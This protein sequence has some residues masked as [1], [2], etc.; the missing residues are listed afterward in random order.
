MPS[1][2]PRLT[3]AWLDSLSSGIVEFER[4]WTAG[5]APRL[6]LGPGAPAACGLCP[7]PE[8][9]VG[10]SCGFLQRA[11][12]E[13][14]FVLPLASEKDID[15]ARDEVYLAG[16]F[17]GWQAAIGRAE[18]RLAPAELDG[19]Q[20]LVWKGQCAGFHASPPPKFKFVTNEYYWFTPP[21]D[22]PNTAR[23]DR[24]NLNRIID[25]SRTGRH[26]W[27]FALEKPIELTGSWSVAV[28]G[29]PGGPVPM[30][31]GPFFHDLST[32]LPLGA[33]VGEGQT[34]FR[35]FA[36]RARTATLH[37]RAEPDG[38]SEPFTYP[39]SRRADADG[40]AGVWEVTLDQDLQG[41]FYWYT[42][43]GVREGPGSFDPAIRILDPYALAAVG[44]E[45]PGIVLSRE[46]IGEG[47]DSLETPAWQDLVI[48]E[49]HVR[50]LTALAPV[51]VT[52][53]ERRG[54]TGLIRWIE[55]PDF[56]LHKLGINCVELQ[57]VHQF[58]SRTPEEYHWGYMPNNYFA[59]A[60]A[61]ALEPAGAS[62]VREFQDVVA[63][64]HS[65]EIAVVLDVVYNHVGL[66]EHLIR[67]DGLYYPQR[68]RD[69]KLSNW[70][71]CGNDLRAGAA[72]VKRLIIDSCLHMIEAYG[73]DGFRFDLAEILGV[74]LLR[75][76]EAALKAV[77]PDVILIA[78]PWSFR[79]HIAGALRDT[80]WASWNDGYRD[81]LPK[82]VRGAGTAA[83]LEYFIRGSPWFFAK[84]PAQTVN[85]VE[86]HDDRT[87]IDTI[88][89][90][91][92]GD[93]SAPTAND[94]RRTH[95]MAAIL[96][97]SAGIPM[98]SAGQDFLR[99][100]RG[101][102]N[103]YQRGDLNALDYRRLYRFL[104][105]HAY[106]A[107]WIDFRLSSR[108]GRLLRQFPR[109][110]DGFYSFFGARDQAPTAMLCNADRSDGPGRLLF[111]VNPTQGDVTVP[112]GSEV[113]DSGPWRLVADQDRFYP[114]GGPGAR[115]PVETNLFLPALG[116]GL[117]ADD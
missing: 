81:F 57:P 36:P 35:L 53:A 88:T 93:G 4:N 25:H 3:R 92:G 55:S 74:A 83:D 21:D 30:G 19:E 17:N 99:S 79:G 11:S 23:D 91:A 76:I 97:M 41:W 27:R 100:K 90:N 61:Y 29:G 63:A 1:S 96:F 8:A 111:A 6:V 70:S 72:M 44:R 67:I 112:I 116:C 31:L 13:F 65:R 14:V 105:T 71:A 77:K 114:S 22:A 7:A 109:P 18:W 51:S 2:R 49:A 26:L 82:Y 85:Y 47:D 33:I 10:N 42:L 20:V 69:G 54:F 38:P 107:D 95:L 115:S 101:I 34:V 46:W 80:G 12:G 110:G 58:D 102:R 64:F 56:Y 68:D 37:I 89:E 52:D 87:W 62:G 98:I 94:R 75:E 59:P 40:A 39:L 28:A 32:S 48:A 78:E 103:T 104:E 43:D 66:P 24:G 16:D 84:W 86:S 5:E 15:P 73:V 50:D 113:A 117:W 108:Q 106:F 45:G 60:S 9:V